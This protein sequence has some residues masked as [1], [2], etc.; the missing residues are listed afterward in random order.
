MSEVPVF[1]DVTEKN[2]KQKSSERWTK[3]CLTMKEILRS[4][5]DGHRDID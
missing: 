3:I 5:T 1:F 4:G 2:I